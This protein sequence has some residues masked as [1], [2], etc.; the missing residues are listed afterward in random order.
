M[1]VVRLLSAGLL[2][3][4][5][6]ATGTLSAQPAAEQPL[7]ALP[8]DDLSRFQPAGAAWQVAGAAWTL[9]DSTGLVVDPGAGVLVHGSDGSPGDP[10]MTRWE[11]GDLI[12]ELDFLLPEG[13]DAGVFLQGRYEVE[14][15][16][17]W[18][19]V[20]PRIRD[21]GGIGGRDGAF[22]GHPPRANASRAPG[23]W[24]H[25]RVVFQAPRFDEAGRKVTDA[26]IVQVVHNG[27]KV[28]E[29]VDVTGP[30]RG[31]VFED[32][33]PAGPLVLQGGDGAAFR[34]IR[35]RHFAPVAP[36]TVSNVR[37]AYYEGEFDSLSDLAAIDP[38]RSGEVYGYV[39]DLFGQ[40][41]DRFGATWEGQ[42]HVPAPGT[43]RFG[44]GFNWV[45]EIPYEEDAVP[46]HGLLTVA[47]REVA[48][49]EGREHLAS[50]SIVL[51][52]GTH[53]F[54][55]TYFKNR[56][57]WRPIVFFQVEGPGMPLQHLNA[58]RTLPRPETSAPPIAVDPAKEPYVLRSFVTYGEEKKVNAVSVGDPAGLHYTLDLADGG[59]LYA[60]KGAFA[61]VGA[62]WH[63]RG[64]QQVARPLGH[65][66]T[67]AAGPA[68]AFLSDAGAPWPAGYGE[69]DYRF[70]GYTLDAEGHPTFR[71][72]LGDVHVTEHL[73]PDPDGRI[74][75][76]TFELAAE[77]P[78]RP[79][80]LRVAEG[81]ELRERRPGVF[82]VDGA[83]FVDTGEA[84]ASVVRTGGGRQELRIPVRFE[85][86]E[87]G[88]TYSIVW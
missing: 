77:G 55:L 42:V 4:S 88:V 66:I 20:H 83:Y 18:G 65:R 86:G 68:L 64:E 52:A 28:Q 11:H 74:L 32:E 70:E 87:A 33:R 2:V 59:L 80:W 26:R 73:R 39:W 34:N 75:T 63:S 30:T 10:L 17:S 38:A 5:I 62:M 58:P 54:T 27:V 69:G 71:Y 76:R 82:S 45:D 15:A 25:L 22:P 41:A 6:G 79:L 44:I 1:I 56:K 53:P 14:L 49:H 35:Y 37:Y 47:G 48:V 3:L 46:G 13:S 40:R 60:W 12:L 72:T 61:D 16:D 24:Q 23:L 19:V 67:L 81:T 51:D 7:E 43:Y 84:G 50:G 85:A 29:N 78:P 8:L 21:A 31:A 57:G 36:V 9:W